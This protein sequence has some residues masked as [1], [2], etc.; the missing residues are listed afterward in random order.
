MANKKVKTNDELVHEFKSAST[1][2]DKLAIMFTSQ[3]SN[4]AATGAKFDA[5]D[6]RMDSF[7]SSM[8]AFDARLGQL[9]SKAVA[10]ETKMPTNQPFLV[11]VGL[12]NVMCIGGFP[13]FTH[14]R[15]MEEAVKPLLAAWGD[16]VTNTNFPSMGTSCK[17]TLRDKDL[18]W[19][20][21]NE[22]KSGAPKITF[23]PQAKELWMNVHMTFEERKESNKLKLVMDAIKTLGQDEVLVPRWYKQQVIRATPGQARGVLCTFDPAS[24]S[25][26]WDEFSN[27]VFNSDQKK[28]VEENFKS[29]LNSM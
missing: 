13:D 7:G 12:R 17:V 14:G 8:S 24:N 3:L 16:E 11:P 28:S 1:L 29:R 21:I 2:D 10:P 9:E 26:S 19:K 25:I 20:R 15:E 22:Y 18:M 4:Q 23:G 5:I 6:Q 27:S